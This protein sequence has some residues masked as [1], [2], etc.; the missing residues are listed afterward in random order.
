[1]ATF[2]ELNIYPLKSARRI[3]KSSVRLAPT[4]FEWDRHWM[5]VN[6]EGT[7][8]SQRTHPKLA[9]IQPE[10]SDTRLT[11]RAQGLSPLSLPLEPHGHSTDVSVWK[12]RC[13]GLTRAARQTPGPATSCR[14]QCDS[15][16]LWTLRNDWR[17]LN[18]RDPY[19]YR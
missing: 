11:L 2:D 18:S 1:M 16:E 12:D 3:E 8:L 13:E 9:W 14:N 4:G 10:I 7:F 17:V 15:F 5:I 19:R 6:V